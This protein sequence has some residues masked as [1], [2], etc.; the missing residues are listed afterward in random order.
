MKYEHGSW[1][2]PDESEKLSA[3]FSFGVYF[4]HN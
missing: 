3:S 4:L 1:D 2:T